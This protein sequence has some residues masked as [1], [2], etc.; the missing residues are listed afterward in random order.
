MALT[1]MDIA[2]MLRKQ[3]GRDRISLS[4]AGAAMDRTEEEAWCYMHQRVNPMPTVPST[5]AYVIPIIPFSRWLFQGGTMMID[6]KEISYGV[7]GYD[8]SGRLVVWEYV[9]RDPVNAYTGYMHGDLIKLYPD[10]A[11]EPSSLRLRRQTVP[12]G[13]AR[14]EF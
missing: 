2:W 12:V 9:G 7:R 4:E 11:I 8:K 1:E 10:Y 13:D 3:Y 14:R 5:D 6:K